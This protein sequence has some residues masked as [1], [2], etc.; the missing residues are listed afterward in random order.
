MYLWSLKSSD[1]N[2]K[3]AERPDEITLLLN[4]SSSKLE[5]NSR[6]MHYCA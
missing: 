6:L 2:S 1:K 5:Q 4:S 3:Q